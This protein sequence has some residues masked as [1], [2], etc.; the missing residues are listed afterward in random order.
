MN[1]GVEV[2]ALNMLG[3]GYADYL[4]MIPGLLQAAGGA[5]STPGAAGAASTQTAAQAAQM[6]ALIDQ[7]KKAEADA[8]STRKYLYVGGGVVGAGLLYY[9]LKGKK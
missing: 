6:Q 1:E 7:Q 5:T 4:K 2:G 9:L 8:A 3:A